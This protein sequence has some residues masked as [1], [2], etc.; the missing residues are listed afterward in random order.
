MLSTFSLIGKSSKRILGF[1]CGK[2]E[3]IVGKLE[4]ADKCTIFTFQTMSLTHSHTM[5]PFDASG[6]EAF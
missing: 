5:T 4:H 3:N 6:K 1:D 2:V